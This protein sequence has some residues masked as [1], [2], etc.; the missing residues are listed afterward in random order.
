MPDPGPTKPSS[1]EPGSALP[2]T[3]VTGPPRT[4]PRTPPGPR[5]IAMPTAAGGPP[6]VPPPSVPLSFLAAGGVGA[7]AFGFGAWLA[8][9]TAVIAPTHPGVV[10]TVHLGVLAFLTTAVLGAMHQF[11][12]V[13]SQRPLRSVLLA[14]VTLVLFVVGAWMLASGFAHGPA[15]LVLIG[16]GLAVTAVVLAVFNLSHA[17]AGQGGVPIVGLRLAAAYLVLTV[18]FGIVYAIAR[19]T[20]WFPLW[21]HRVLA[22]AHLGLLGWMGL[23]YLAV[24]EKLWPM[25]LLSHRPSNRSGPLAVG[26]VA[27]GTLVLATGLLFAVKGVAV[28]GALV[29]IGGLAAHLTSLAGSVRH[30]RRSL[31][32]LHAYLFASATALVAAVVL[33]VV[34]GLA[35]LSTLTRSRLVAAEVAALIAWLAL[36]VIGHAHK[37]VPFITY[38]ALRAKGIRTN[39]EG[40]PLLFAHLL[41]ARAARVSFVGACVGYGSLVSGLAVGSEPLVSVGGAAIAATAIVVTVNL[42]LGPRRA[43]PPAVLPSLGSRPGSGA[44]SGPSTAS[45]STPT[46]PTSPTSPTTPTA[47][48]TTPPTGPPGDPSSSPDSL[49][50]STS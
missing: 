30:R 1:T 2:P 46:S 16:G 17:L 14:R 32:L 23:T 12:P 49:S 6:S 38:G 29:V 5:L 40:K 3:P 21:S 43:G 33:G 44:T 7:V 24:A 22:H 18:S 28:V 41:D 4:P 27:G 10:G 50:R 36:A 39:A 26:L 45:P 25:F 37:I 11:T 20:G 35:D 31:E 42:S 48:A 8:A 13:V 19:H 15:N 47:S 34:A 9:D